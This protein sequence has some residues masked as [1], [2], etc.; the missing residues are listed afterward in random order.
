LSPQ[1]PSAQQ[2]ALQFSA[3]FVLQQSS[4]QQVSAQHISSSIGIVNS[5]SL[6]FDFHEFI[7]QEI[8]FNDK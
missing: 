1:H 4:A 8:L 6:T 2:D 5:L 3:Q 7:L